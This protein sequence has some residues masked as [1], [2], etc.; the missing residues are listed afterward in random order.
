[1]L[2]RRLMVATG[3]VPR[4]FARYETGTVNWFDPK[5][6]YGFIKQENGK[7]VFVH[8]TGLVDRFLLEGDEVEFDPVAQG[9]RVKA[10]NVRGGTGP[11][12]A[13]WRDFQESGGR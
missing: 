6:G 10:E 4:R 9:D 5:K 8:R 3:S 11:N 1:M 7:D 13:D 12:L 2:G